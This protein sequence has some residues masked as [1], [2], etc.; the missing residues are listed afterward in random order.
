LLTA[1]LLTSVPVPVTVMAKLYSL[2][3]CTV[4]LLTMQPS[5]MLWTAALS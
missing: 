3:A 1:V 2:V 4:P 5:P